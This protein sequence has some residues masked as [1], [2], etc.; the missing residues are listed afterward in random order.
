MSLVIDGH[1]LIGT[2]VF[3]D[4]TLADVD[5]EARLVARLRVWKSRYKGPMTVIFDRG[6]TAG[7]SANLSGAGVRV[8]FARNPEEADD[9]IRRRIRKAAKGLVVVTNDRLLREEAATAGVE[10]WNGEKFVQRMSLPPAIPDQPEAGADPRLSLSPQEVAEWERL[11][12]EERNREET[13]WRPPPPKPPRSPQGWRPPPTKKS[14]K[15]K[16][17]IQKSAGSSQQGKPH[18]KRRQK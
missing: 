5:D 18:G 4:I 12:Q 17:S 8:I 2:N 6:V 3:P 1:N 7:Q 14:A 13:H 11:F 15:G 10:V 16:Q 9:L